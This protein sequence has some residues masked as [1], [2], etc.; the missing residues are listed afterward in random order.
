MTAL[1]AI[2]S[3]T[4]LPTRNQSTNIFVNDDVNIQDKETLGTDEEV[5][6]GGRVSDSWGGEGDLS[7]WPGG[8]ALVLKLLGI[9]F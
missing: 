5:T 4:F 7:G 9:Y 3:R 6:E 2:C 1:R 8:K